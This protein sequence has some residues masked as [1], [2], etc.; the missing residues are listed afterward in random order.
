MKSGA[1]T[2]KKKTHREAKKPKNPTEP[3]QRRG[4][5]DKS[6]LRRVN[7]AC[8]TALQEADFEKKFGVEIKKNPETGKVEEIVKKKKDE[9]DILMRKAR[10]E[11]GK[12]IK[13]KPKKTVTEPRLTKAEKRKLKLK[14]KKEKKLLGKVDDFDKYKD[15]VKFGEIAHAPPSLAVPKK[16]ATKLVAKVRRK[17]IK[18]FF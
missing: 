5:S 9:I 15:T 17:L 11:D 18:I 12:K 7:T 16:L 6:F 10:K 14:V 4:E 8:E 2:K 3:V 1:F 13:K